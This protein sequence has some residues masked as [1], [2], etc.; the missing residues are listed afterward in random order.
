MTPQELIATAREAQHNSYSPYSG[1]KVGAALLTDNG[2]IYTGANIE[3]ASYGLTVCAERT[4]FF[5]A[6]SKGERGFTA[7][8]I[9]GDGQGYTYPCGACL[10]VFA[11]FSPQIK[12]LVT[13]EKDNYQE[14]FLKDLM[15]QFF[16]L[17]DREVNI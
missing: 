8:A 13:D 11:E 6:V 2:N 16:S 10:Q 3:N 12:I 9:A 5:N 7:I 4:A 1:F 17:E 15:P 14:C